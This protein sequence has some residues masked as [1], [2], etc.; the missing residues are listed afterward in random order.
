MA[1]SRVVKLT[2]GL[3]L[4]FQMKLLPLGKDAT[5]LPAN[6]SCQLTVWC[7]NHGKRCTPLCDDWEMMHQEGNTATCSRLCGCHDVVLLWVLSS[8]YRRRPLIPV[9]E[10][11][12]PNAVV[13]LQCAAFRFCFRL[14]M[15]VSLQRCADTHC[16]RGVCVC[17]RTSRSLVSLSQVIQRQE[18]FFFFSYCQTATCGAGVDDLRAAPM[19]WFFFC[20]FKS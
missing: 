12:W 7:H 18:L 14:L 15:L 10:C 2:G 20:N 4:K 11:C 17:G 5:M 9:C 3:R 6:L 8:R 16:D 1:N 19:G 13:H